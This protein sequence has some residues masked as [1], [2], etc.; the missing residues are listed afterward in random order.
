VAAATKLPDIS[1][2]AVDFFNQTYKQLQE[3][4]VPNP[5]EKTYFIVVSSQGHAAVP[6]RHSSKTI[7]EKE[8]DR[9]SKQ[10]PGTTFTVFEAKSSLVTPKPDTKKTEYAEPFIGF[11]P[12]DYNLYFNSK[13]PL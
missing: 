3:A 4:L 9:L 12:Y 8:A 11:A 13:Y 6:V 1:K 10:H 2:L 7:A 5:T